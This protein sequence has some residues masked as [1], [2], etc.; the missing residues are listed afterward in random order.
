MSDLLTI[1]LEQIL[2]YLSQFTMYPS[3]ER[4]TSRP[5]KYVKAPKSFILNELCSKILILKFLIKATCNEELVHIGKSHR[6]VLSYD[7]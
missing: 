3:E 1:K 5:K 4:L 2:L 6:S 7:E